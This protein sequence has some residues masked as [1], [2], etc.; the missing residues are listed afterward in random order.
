[1]R[2]SVSKIENASSIFGGAGRFALPD[3][4]A[5]HALP[6]DAHV[7]RVAAAAT[8]L[9]G[10]GIADD[11]QALAVVANLAATAGG[12]ADFA[13]TD[14]V[15][16][17]AAALTTARAA[18]TVTGAAHPIRRTVRFA[19]RVLVRDLSRRARA[20]LAAAIR[21]AAVAAVARAVGHA[22]GVL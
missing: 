1:T 18:A 22:A 9:D 12:R 14:A 6:A 16:A 4:D 15:L 2:V 21:H 19:A 10:V 7:A 17:R 13:R 5:G 3:A 11:R 8:A 20:G